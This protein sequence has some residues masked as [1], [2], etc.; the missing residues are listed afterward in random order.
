[1]CNGK[2]SRAIRFQICSF[3]RFSACS[4]KK[5]NNLIKFLLF[6]VAFVVSHLGYHFS[7]LHCQIMLVSLENLLILA[8]INQRNVHKICTYILSLSLPLAHFM[9]S[10]SQFIKHSRQRFTAIYMY[11]R[12]LDTVLAK[13][14]HVQKDNIQ[15]VHT[16]VESIVAAVTVVDRNA[17]IQR[18]GERKRKT[19]AVALST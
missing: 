14:V 17:H 18:E 12:L 5:T 6:F 16:V 2:R 11:A 9:P 15:I 4:E 7:L 8:N 1:M 10:Y 3:H 13:Y 19:R